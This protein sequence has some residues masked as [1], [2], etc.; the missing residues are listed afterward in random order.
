MSNMTENFDSSAFEAASNLF[1]DIAYGTLAT[2]SSKIAELEQSVEHL[3]K[4]LANLVVGYGEQ[5]VFMEALVAQLAFAK[6]EERRAFSENLSDARNKMLEV[7]RDASAT[8]ADEDQGIASAITDLAS[9]K[10]SDP[11]I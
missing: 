5:A 4:Q 1:K 6:P 8:M 10:L 11:D 2:V 7:M 9:E 3:E